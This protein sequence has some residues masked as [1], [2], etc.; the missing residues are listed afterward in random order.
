MAPL[1]LDINDDCLI[2]IFKYLTASELLDIASTCSRFQPVARDV[3]SRHHKSTCVEIDLRRGNQQRNRFITR[4]RKAA[5]ILRIFG[6]SLRILKVTFCCSTK[7]KLCNIR[8]FNMMVMYCTGGLDQLELIEFST[9]ADNSREIINPTA[10]FRNVKQLTLD[11]AY[12]VEATFLSDAKQLTRLKLIGFDCE[13]VPALLSN[14][15]PRLRSL[16][17]T[18]NKSDGWKRHQININ[19]YLKQYPQLIEFEL[20]DGILYDFSSICK[21]CPMLSKLSISSQTYNEMAILHLDQLTQLTALKL[22]APLPRD[23][24]FK[25]LNESK[26]SQ[27]LEELELTAVL[28]DTRL[29][30][31]AALPRFNNLK[32][33]S[34]FLPSPPPSAMID[35][36]LVDLVRQLSHLEWL[37]LRA[38]KNRGLLVEQ[39]T[40]LQ[41][42]QIYYERNQKLMISGY[43]KPFFRTRK[44]YEPFVRLNQSEFVKYI[45]G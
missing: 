32:N 28:D 8:I 45:I 11:Y 9:T 36:D 34:I 3:F 43:G 23:S 33:L 25:F 17:M 21:S 7:T 27:S 13:D 40:Y 42:C 44:P 35:Y 16:T 38:M 31:M 20:D 1:L 4:R 30:V 18:Q 26:S 5:A 29:E 19:N 2:E 10:L 12:G 14:D 39:R 6:A 37:R 15:Y 24:L 41:I 22:E